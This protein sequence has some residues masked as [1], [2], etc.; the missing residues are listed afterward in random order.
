MLHYSLHY[1]SP[2]MLF[3]TFTAIHIFIS[4]II[5]EGIVGDGCRGDI[6]IDDFFLYDGLCQPKVPERTTAQCST[7][8]PVV[9][10]TRKPVVTTKTYTMSTSSTKP[11]T[12]TVQPYNL[13]TVDIANVT[14]DDSNITSTKELS[15]TT[16]KML[17]TQSSSV[18]DNTTPTRTSLSASKSTTP[19]SS[20]SSTSKPTQTTQP[21]STQATSL[22]VTTTSDVRAGNMTGLN[23]SEPTSTQGPSSDDKKTNLVVIIVPIVATVVAILAVGGILIGRLVYKRRYMSHNLHDYIYD[24]TLIS[25]GGATSNPVYLNL[26]YDEEYVSNGT[27]DLDKNYSQP[28][29]VSK[30]YKEV[31]SDSTSS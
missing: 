26:S 25:G 18:I 9:S 15:T 12:S 29:G 16:Y 21:P 14:V 5:V 22:P 28:N 1:N 30:G 11:S 31:D 6:A 7:S 2:K 4:Q 3:D 27:A 20:S 23:A 24:D 10:T 17:S 13:T 8:K 19:I